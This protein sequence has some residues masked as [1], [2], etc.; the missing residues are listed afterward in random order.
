[1][2]TEKQQRIIVEK[3]AD[4]KK[5]TV[6][7]RACKRFLVNRAIE[8]RAKNK[9]TE[10]SNLLKEELKEGKFS[11]DI[12]DIDIIEKSGSTT[13]NK[14]VLKALYPEVFNDDRIWKVGEPYLALNKVTIRVK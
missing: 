5:V 10:A 12:Y 6:L 1:M 9:K 8:E 2:T 7:A 4:T 13:L 14:E 11:C 3:L